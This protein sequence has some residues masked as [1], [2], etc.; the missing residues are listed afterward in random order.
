MERQ[1]SVG[2]NLWSA[3][4]G[5]IDRW[6]RHLDLMVPG[7]ACKRGHDGETPGGLSQQAPPNL[8]S[9]LP[10]RVPPH[11]A[12]DLLL[13]NQLLRKWKRAATSAYGGL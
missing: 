3:R 8:Q 13:P 11:D 9:H 12:F 2:S 10:Q 4:R 1:R 5:R 7:G 6:E